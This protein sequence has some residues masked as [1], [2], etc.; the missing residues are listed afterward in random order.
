M[1]FVCKRVSI[2]KLQFTCLKVHLVYLFSIKNDPTKE[3]LDQS[4]RD[5]LQNDQQPVKEVFT[6][7]T[8]CVFINPDPYNV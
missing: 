2:F 8:I 3:L 7:P 6:P 5:S 1:R 4:G